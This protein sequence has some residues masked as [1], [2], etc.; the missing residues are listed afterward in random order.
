M[1]QTCMRLFCIMATVTILGS[2]QQAP[3]EPAQTP[4]SDVPSPAATSQPAAPAQP[5]PSA[6][7][8]PQKLALGEQLFNKSCKVCHGRRGN[9]IG[10]RGGPSLQRDQFKYGRDINAI[11]Q[12]IRDGRPKGM[13]AFNKAFT[14]DTIDAVAQYVLS[15]KK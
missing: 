2:C 12:S 9:G 7:A 13:P 11:T 15:L 14:P 4:K 8:D 3:Q 6:V 10:T 5:S 1:K